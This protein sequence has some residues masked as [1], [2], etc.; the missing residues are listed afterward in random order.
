MSWE[1]TDTSS[2]QGDRDDEDTK[3]NILRNFTVLPH[4]ASVN[5]PAI[6]KGRLAANQALETSN[7]LTTVIEDRVGDSGSVKG[8]EYAVDKGVASREVSRGI[9]LVTRLVE[10]GVRID[11]PQHLIAATGVIPNAVI[12]DRDVARVPSVGIPNREDY[13]SREERTQETVKYAVEGVD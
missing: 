12:V 8:K 5:V 6:G 13:R 11:Y 2:A 9:S 1:S 7:N 4:E 10:G 3:V